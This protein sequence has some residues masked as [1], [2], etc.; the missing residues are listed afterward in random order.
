ME[1]G[2]GGVQRHGRLSLSSVSE[3]GGSEAEDTSKFPV[4]T[5]MWSQTLVTRGCQS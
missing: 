1:F 4:E 2:G 3:S 5:E